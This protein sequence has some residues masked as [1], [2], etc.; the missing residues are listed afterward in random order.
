[1]LSA[2]GACATLPDAVWKPAEKLDVGGWKG[3][4]T[5]SASGNRAS[6]R[7]RASGGG[8]GAADPLPS[9]NPDSNSAGLA[10]VLSSPNSASA[11]ARASDGGGGASRPLAS[12]SPLLWTKGLSGGGLANIGTWLEEGSTAAGVANP[13][14]GAGV[15]GGAGDSVRRRLLGASSNSASRSASRIIFSARDM[16][17]SDGLASARPLAVA[18]ATNN[19]TSAGAGAGGL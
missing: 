11:L 17:A 9:W 2:L 1:M 19:G 15:G 13:A 3:P 10:G 5:E 18:K 7:V 6:A 4:A 14:T 16:A 8:G 12:L